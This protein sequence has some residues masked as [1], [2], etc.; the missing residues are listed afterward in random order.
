MKDLI[1]FTESPSRL[2]EFDVSTKI[3]ITDKSTYALKSAKTPKA[4]N[5][6]DKT[7]NTYEHLKKNEKKFIKLIS[8]VPARN[9]DGGVCF[10]YISGT[11]AERLLLDKI[12]AKDEI[13]TFRLINQ[14]IDAINSLDEII[15]DPTSN[16][17]YVDVFGSSINGV[18]PCA[19]TGLVDLNLDNIII[20][21]SGWNLIDYEWSFEFP[22]PKIYL[23]QRFFYWFFSHRY[24]EILL[25][26]HENLDLIELGSSILVPSYIYN[27]YKEYFNSLK[28]TVESES[29]FQF[30]V[31]GSHIKP[32]IFFG[33]P[34]NFEVTPKTSSL[35]TLLETNSNL[36]NTNA[37]LEQKYN[38]A[39]KEIESIKNSKKYKLLEKASILKAKVLHN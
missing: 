25:L 17:T 34:Y 33:K 1:F 14:L 15:I 5:H 22:V 38:D 28:D 9:K 26:N 32:E 13:T 8:P 3:F 19:K 24:K 31:H 27:M 23:V 7:I 35:K 11:N 10:D 29:F 16:Q 4:Q 12:L 36:N 6:I 18:Q 21:G 39:I 20:N 37:I 30:Y 2:S